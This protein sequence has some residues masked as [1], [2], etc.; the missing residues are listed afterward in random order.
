MLDQYCTGAALVRDYCFP[1]LAAYKRFI[2]DLLA[3]GVSFFVLQFGP[4]SPEFRCRF[5]FPVVDL[6]MLDVAARRN[7]DPIH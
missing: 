4:G 3:K 5:A 6:P 2:N 1:D 7:F